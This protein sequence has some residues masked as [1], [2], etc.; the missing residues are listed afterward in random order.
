[1]EKTIECV[2]RDRCTGCGACYNKCPVGAI[3]M[4]Y[5]KEG[6]LFPY[7]DKDKCISCGLCHKACP[8]LNIELVRS[9]MHEEGQCYAAMAEDDIRMISSSGGIFTLMAD[10]IYSQNGVVCGA[11]YSDDYQYV[12]HIISESKEDLDLLRGSKYV[13]SDTKETYKKIEGALSK[14]RKVL[15]VGCPCQVSGLYSFLNKK[16][17]NLYTIDLVCHGANSI[18]AYQ[19]YIKEIANGRII[20]SVNFRDKS[21]FGWSS[22]VTVKFIDG[23]SYNAAWNKNKWYDCFSEGIMIRECCSSCH[24][25]QKKRIGDITLGDFWQVHKWDESCNDWKGTSLVLA[26]DCKGEYLFSAIQDRLKLSKEASIDFAAKYNGQLVRP[27]KKADGR[28]YF[29]NHLEKD[30]YHKAWW[31]GHKWRYDVGLIGWWFAANYGSVLTYYAL[32]RILEDMNLL[33]IM[34]R[35]PKL[36]GTGWESITQRNVEFMQNY[37]PV[38]KTRKYENIDEYN[39]FCDAFMLGSDQLWV[40]FYNNMVGYT[41]FLDFADETKRKIAYAT[42][43]G[44]DKYEGSEE[45]KQIVK[46]LLRRF[47]AISVRESSGVEVCKNEFDV[48]AVRMLDPVF[49][50]EKKYYDLLADNSRIARNYPYILCYILDPTEEKRQAIRLIEEK[51]GMKSVV[52]LDMKSF[53]KCSKL[54][55]NE[56]VIY[57][58]GIEE[59]IYFIKNCKYMITDSHHGA[60]F[61]M[62]YHKNFVAIANERRGKTR[63]ESLFNL[64]RLNYLLLEEGDLVDKIANVADV[65]YISVDEILKQEIKASKEWLRQAYNSPKKKSSDEIELFAKYLNSSKRLQTLHK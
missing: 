35:I 25:A 16:Y 50:C 2:A 26:N 11:V 17:D 23:T 54:W 63:F 22:S 14:G 48:E 3:T 20:K 27:S 19:S 52:I 28:K 7:I 15:F 12:Y 4:K 24:Y 51:Y 5:N 29:F 6:F 33:P 45:D 39:K 56:N 9:R 10:Y 65:D 47:D 58:V 44:R 59:F 55:I 21:V 18:Y 32:G 13:Q 62:I 36:D 8:E 64:L 1:M 42:S 53:E 60:C 61:A 38:S 49:L 46:S 30:G 31:Y 57:N 37:F 34:L 43:I 41:F 40:S